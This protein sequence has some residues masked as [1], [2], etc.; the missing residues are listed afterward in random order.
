[1]GDFTIDLNDNDGGIQNDA[2]FDTI[3]E[4]GNFDVGGISQ[5]MFRL[6]TCDATQIGAR[7]ITPY[8]SMEGRKHGFLVIDYFLDGDGSTSLKIV[9]QDQDNLCIWK[10]T[11]KS[12]GWQRAGI[13][14]KSPSDPRFFIEAGCNPGD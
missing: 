6:N 12:C 14:I 9:K 4:Y 11:N 5:N 2:G 8:F 1:M 3:F 10:D 7:L 13:V